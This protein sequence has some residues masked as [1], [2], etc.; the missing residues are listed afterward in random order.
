MQD[1]RYL[2]RNFLWVPDQQ[3]PDDKPAFEL[4]ADRGNW[5]RTLVTVD[6]DDD[7][8]HTGFRATL[9]PP[10]TVRART[11]I[12]ISANPIRLAVSIR[13][14]VGG[15]ADGVAVTAMK[16]IGTHGAVAHA[17]LA[18]W[19]AALDVAA[20]FVAVLELTLSVVAV[21]IRRAVIAALSTVI[22]VGVLIDARTSATT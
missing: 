8:S 14:D 21:L 1:N 10:G 16:G 5:S 12:A 15:T 9:P 20:E 3:S 22:R 7:P 18:V 13:T 6:T 17:L 11:T 2:F 4:Y 19:I